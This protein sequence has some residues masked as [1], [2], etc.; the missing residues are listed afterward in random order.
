MS[1]TVY[2]TPISN[3]IGA[4]SPVTL[5]SVVSEANYRVGITI[6]T[7]RKDSDLTPSR[8]IIA[9]VT[10]IDPMGLHMAWDASVFLDTYPDICTSEDHPMRVA[11]GTNIVLQP[12]ADFNDNADTY[13]LY[14]CLELL[15]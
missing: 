11:A 2:D 6:C 3:Q 5:A 10:W 13:S 4:F 15:T 7:V 14:P 1:T 12:G 9:R 8:A